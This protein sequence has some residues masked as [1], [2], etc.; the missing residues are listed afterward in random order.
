MRLAVIVAGVAVGFVFLL[1][2]LAIGPARDAQ[3]AR[4]TARDRPLGA[5]PTDHR[6]A[7]L[8]DANRAAWSS[9]GD[10]QVH[11]IE[12]A[13][14]DPGAPLP[15][16]ATRIPA[17]GQ[18]LVSPALGRLLDSPSGRV[19]RLRFPG[20]VAGTLGRPVLHDPN[21]LVAMVGMPASLLADATQITDWSGSAPADVGD[22]G[23]TF[24]RRL[25]YLLAALGVLV[26]I[27]VFVA[28]S[29]RI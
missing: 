2:A 18:V 10:R 23:N 27:G 7:L 5:A 3:D 14:T 21:E 29:T 1:G 25:V 4:Q 16:G 8:W 9:I 17:A 26:P 19:Y 6:P 15:L 22:A 20:R 11:V 24:N 28:A 13:A 12:V